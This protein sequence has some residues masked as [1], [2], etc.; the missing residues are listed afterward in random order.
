M[1]R[2]DG[3]VSTLPSSQAFSPSSSLRV[4]SVERGA[5]NVW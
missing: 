1:S 2:K 5:D 4:L 3:E